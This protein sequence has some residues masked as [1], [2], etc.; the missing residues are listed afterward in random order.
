MTAQKTSELYSKS[1]GSS[2]HFPMLLLNFAGKE[3]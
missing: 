3:K 2:S 1:L